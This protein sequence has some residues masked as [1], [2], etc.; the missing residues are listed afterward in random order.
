MTSCRSCHI[1]GSPRRLAGPALAATLLLSGSLAMAADDA[2]RVSAVRLDGSRVIGSLQ[3]F[4]SGKVRIGSADGRAR[5]VDLKTDDVL[6][7]ELAERKS[8]DVPATVLEFANGD[9]I[10]VEVG[11]VEGDVLA[12]TFGDMPLDV[13]LEALRGIRFA[14]SDA[15]DGSSA[16]LLREEG[17]DDLVLLTNGDRLAG[18]FVGLSGTELRL[19]SGGREVRVPRDRIVVLSLSPELTVPATIDGPRQIVQS[20]RGW[21]TVRDL[22][23]TDDGSWTATTAFGETVAWPAGTVGSVRFAGGRG[24]FLSE[25][26]PAGI[27]FEP[28]LDR[29]WPL[30]RDRD[31]TG[32]PLAVG[33]E[34]FPTGLGTHSRSRATYD[35]GGRYAAFRAV[36]GLAPSAGEVGSAE[37]AVEVDGR[38]VFRSDPVT[39]AEA[40]PVAIELT[41]AET[42]VLS[43]D[44]GR[45]GDVRDRA[46]WCDAVL[47]RK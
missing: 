32:A 43:V 4:G 26:E 30:R 29:V 10:A 1:D 15:E 13:P 9:R 47:V 14:S 36:I 25:I 42:L 19:D 28:Y 8:A 6:S 35:L 20:S 2:A 39:A 5:P 23:R 21:L 40:K 31:V 24:E 46:N 37:F 7:F 17:A 3:S 33:G 18:E 45:N 44:Y 22:T 41:G 27:E 16:W 34:V 38:E 11:V 12:A